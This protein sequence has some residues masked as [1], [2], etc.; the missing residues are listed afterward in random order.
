MTNTRS[1]F[2]TKMNQLTHE[3]RKVIGVDD[4]VLLSNV[5]D[6]GILENLK[7]RHAADVIYTFI[8]HV[9]VV[10]RYLAGSDLVYAYSEPVQMAQNLR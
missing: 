9:L 2:V 1:G 10:G 6:K 7:L 8:G 3:E 4:M 5:S